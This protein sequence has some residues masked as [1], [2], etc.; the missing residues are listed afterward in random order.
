MTLFNTK[1]DKI[2]IS[3]NGLLTLN[4]ASKN[5]NYEKL[6]CR[7]DVLSLWSPLPAYVLAPFW[8][9]LFIYK[10]TPQGMYYEETG[11]A[12]ARKLEVEWYVSRYNSP[13]D[14]YHFSLLLDE[15]KP[16]IVVF[17][18][19]EALDKGGKCTVGVQGPKCES[20]PARGPW[21]MS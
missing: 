11:V 7:G 16:N 2:Y 17:K 12:P 4:E 14:Y 20:P 15:A 18:Y 6:P 10:G 3:S 9:D 21:H 19:F 8:A 5:Y 1:S 13:D